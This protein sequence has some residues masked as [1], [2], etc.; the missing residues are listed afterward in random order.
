MTPRCSIVV[1]VHG[2][3]GLTRRCLE[4]LLASPPRVSHEIVVV[5]DA[6][7][8]RMP[9]LLR[10]YGD[11]IRVLHR[12]AQGGFAVACN[13]GAAVAAG[14]LLVF[15]N[16]DTEAHDGWLD[17]LVSH[18][19]RAPAAAVIGARLL[20]P[21]G[22]VQH[23]G[24]VV[25]ADGNP[26]H[27]Y[28]GFP[29]DHP[30]VVHPR[31]LQ[32]VTAA[33][34]L[35]R[36]G[37]FEDAGGFDAGYRNGLE[38]VD[39]CLRLRERGFEVHYCPDAVLT[40][41]ESATRGRRSVEIE[42]N[43][44]RF[45]ARW[46]D[47][48][49][50]D[51]LDW[52]VA[53]GLLELGYEHAHPHR[54]RVSP[55]LATVEGR[56]LERALARRS[57]QVAELLRE[58]VRLTARIAELELGSPCGDAAAPTP[59][60]ATD[61]ISRADELE[62]ELLALQ[63]ALAA[64]TAGSAAL[65]PFGPAPQLVYR[66]LVERIRAIVQAEVPPGGTVAV[67]S[68]GDDDL[69]ELDGRRAWHFPRDERGEYAGHHPAD[70]TAAIAELERLRL[71]GADYLLIPDTARW[72]LDHYADFAAHLSSRYPLVHDEEGACRLYALGERS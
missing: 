1:P 58:V 54:L 37:P 5:D 59:V 18:A 47:R 55:L 62:R 45:R 22:T 42:A 11:R 66:R 30:A 53:D 46:G 71:E 27:L 70:S 68:R 43:A 32:A 21:D 26:R 41:L 16:N 33:C 3:A 9:E 12:A 35:V 49:R 31:A 23:A 51:E 52:Y 20:Y 72:W 63:E 28:A 40:H 14:E 4:A 19:E 38:D 61:I 25:C 34:M 44:R 13:Q 69:I 64:R 65:E 17:A 6:S 29:G 57:R 48:V 39:L 24:V 2:K 50:P 56:D 67:A 10:G 60:G 15:L 36:R 8:A 7:G